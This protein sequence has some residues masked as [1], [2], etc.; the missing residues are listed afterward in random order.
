MCAFLPYF[1]LPLWQ[2]LC[3]GTCDLKLIAKYSYEPSDKEMTLAEAALDC[4][5]ALMSCIE[6]DRYVKACLVSFGYPFYPD[7]SKSAYFND[8]RD[9][10]WI[11]RYFH[12]S[13]YRLAE[14]A[15]RGLFLEA[16]E[17]EPEK[18]AYAQA[19]EYLRFLF[20]TTQKRYG[21][22]FAMNLWE[23]EYGEVRKQSKS[24][25]NKKAHQGTLSPVACVTRKAPT[26]IF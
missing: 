16:G 25:K 14:A 11:P 8:L 18:V 5:K 7:H 23:L 1:L 20:T 17:P 9:H 13:R 2:L 19:A 6:A 22:A 4:K 12:K 15:R 3:S 10:H 21:N 24:R 26:I